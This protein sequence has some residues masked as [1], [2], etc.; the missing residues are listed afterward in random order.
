MT[1]K[2]NAYGFD[3]EIFGKDESKTKRQPIEI[4]NLIDLSKEIIKAEIE[5]Y[6]TF[7]HPNINLAEFWVKCQQEV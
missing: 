1:D 2:G 6:F 5:D 4:G 3:R 7:H